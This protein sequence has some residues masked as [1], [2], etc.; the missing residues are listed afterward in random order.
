MGCDIHGWVEVKDGEKWVA[1]KEL[2]DG[3]RNYERFALLA[4]VRERDYYNKNGAAPK[5]IPVDV[6][7][8]VAYHIKQWGYDGH[9]HSYLPLVDAAKIFLETDPN[10]TDFAK[11]YPAS[12]YFDFEDDDNIENARLVFWFDN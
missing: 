10:P 5:G 7:E 1:V 11:E 9:S 2:K 3:Q 8:T 4:G 12:E 6:S